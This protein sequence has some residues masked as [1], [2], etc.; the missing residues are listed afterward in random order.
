MP[1]SMRI[2]QFRKMAADDP[3]NEIGH[4]SLGR[5]L[6]EAGEFAEAS[7]SLQR[8]IALNP[9]ISKAYQLLGDAQLKL[10]LRDLGIETLKN[11]A[12]VAN[13]RGDLMPKNEMLRKLTEL[14]VDMPELTQQKAKPTELGEGQIQCNRCNQIKPKMAH[15]PFS[16]AQGKLIQEKICADCWREWIGMGTKVINELRLPLSDPQAQ[17]VF[18][19]HMLEFLNLG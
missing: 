10:G 4:F 13:Q 8:V 15:P 1:D 14:G 3:N 2:E 12:R 18:D 7:K 11:G 5:A 17:K 16:N 6:L 9:N 19:Q